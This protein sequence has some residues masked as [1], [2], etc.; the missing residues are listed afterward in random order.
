MYQQL[1]AN[2]RKQVARTV[3]K[4]KIVEQP[5]A[6][7]PPELVAI[8]PGSEEA[9]PETAQGGP[10]AKPVLARSNAPAVNQLRT[11]RD[12]APARQVGTRVATAPK[13][14]R[15]DPCHCGSGLKFKKCHGATSA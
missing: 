14:G 5:S 10:V 4:V 3:F 8:H 9:E 11:N 13:V 1:V 7:P 6:P 15:N 12:D 2:I